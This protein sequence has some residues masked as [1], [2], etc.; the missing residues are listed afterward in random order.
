MLRGAV[1]NRLA[2]VEIDEVA[3]DAVAWR[4]HLHAHPEL[5]FH[6]QETARF[7]RETLASFGGLEIESPTATSVVARLR[8][9]RPGPTL[10]LRADIDALPIQEES[11]VEFSSRTEGVMHACGHDGHTAILLAVARLLVAR[12]AEVSG[13]IRFLFQHAEEV[14]PGGAAE[15]VASGALEG[16]DAVLGGHLI[17]TLEVGKVA[18]L[19]GVCTAA[20]DTFTVRIHGH[21]GHAA[22]P[23]KTVDPI[24][25]SAQ[26]I[27]NLQHIVSRN[28][29]PLES[30]V[31]SVT[32][33]AGGTADN[34]IPESIEFGGTVRSYRQEARERTRETMAR[35]LEGVTAAHGASYELDYVEGYGSVVNDP[36]LAAIVRMAAGADRVVGF[37]RLMAGDDFSAYLRVA[38]GCFFFIG[39]GDERA[40][41]HHHPRFTIDERALPVGIDT[42]TQ[43]TLRFLA[44][45][46]ESGKVPVSVGR[47][48][49]TRAE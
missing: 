30:I 16:A 38:P 39:G 17:S 40:F 13:E 29:P 6:E 46:T 32:R 24:A 19:D 42:F 34:V 7:I 43:A 47:E 5:S 1:A 22:F 10:A 25:V 27:T 37:D 18:A 9:G 49:V 23:H 45:D 3:A 14:P 4:R 36:R 20:A 8:G 15:L 33:I 2:S 48:G 44:D 41:P 21:G 12:R 28:T 26:A 35:I 31:L 11:G